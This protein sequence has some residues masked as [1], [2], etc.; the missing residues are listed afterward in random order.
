METTEIGLER[1]EQIVDAAC[2]LYGEKGIERTSVK[3]VTERAGI[4]RSLFY[5]YFSNKEQV[6]D[7]IL[8]RYVTS[9]VTAVKA[10]NEARVERDVAGALRHCVVLLRQLLFERDS[11]RRLLLNKEN[12]ALYLNFSQR[13]AEAVA[14]YLT[15]TTAVD[16][17]KFHE[18]GI[19]HVYES[20]YLLIFGLIGF[21]RQ[22]PEASDELL[23]DLIADTLHLDLSGA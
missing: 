16:Y 14:R 4:T 7:A 1:R 2:A 15:E 12:A 13:A 9:F 6:T 19:K 17:V 22:H 8:E 5:H 11:F 21:M 3:D 20:F 23:A 10:W 18:L